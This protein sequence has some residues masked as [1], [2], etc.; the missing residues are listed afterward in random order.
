MPRLARIQPL[1]V[2]G[3]S[4]LP[5]PNRRRRVESTGRPDAGDSGAQGAALQAERGQ[6]A[7][8][9]RPRPR[10]RVAR[11]PGRGALPDRRKDGRH[12]HPRRLRTAPGLHHLRPDGR[13]PPEV[14]QPAGGTGVLRLPEQ[15]ARTAAARRLL[16][17]YNGVG[18]ARDRPA[19]GAGGQLPGRAHP[20]PG[21][22][23]RQPLPVGQGGRRGVHPG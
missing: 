18:P 14:R 13:R 12:H 16:R 9:R 3:S 20:S 15:P 5:Q 6:P 1:S 17:P 21:R 22:T 11:G 19:P 8:H 4:G 7:H 2:G 23:R 10:C